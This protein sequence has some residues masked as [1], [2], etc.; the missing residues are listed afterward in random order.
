M[1]NQTKIHSCEKEKCIGYYNIHVNCRF[2][3]DKIN[4]ECLRKKDET[5]TK[6]FLF[7]LGLMVEIL[8]DA[9]DGKVYFAFHGDPDSNKIPHFT[10]AFNKT[11]PFGLTCDT[12]DKKFRNFLLIETAANT[13]MSTATSNLSVNN[14]KQATLNS[15]LTAKPIVPPT[16]DENGV[17]TLYVSSSD[18]NSTPDRIL[19]YLMEKTGMSADVLMVL[20]LRSRRKFRKTYK[21][22]KITYFTED[23]GI[24]LCK[25]DTWSSDF[26]VRAFGKSRNQIG[27]KKPDHRNVN[28]RDNKHNTNQSDKNNNKW[29]RNV[30]DKPDYRGKNNNKNWRRNHSDHR[31]GFKSLSQGHRMQRDHSR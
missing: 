15:T 20:P 6:K 8:D 4:A 9:D 19:A 3:G 29:R 7:M 23:V 11:S 30:R 2:C 16:R 22:F 17:F 31:S 10:D 12:C 21:A 13:S 27:N 25:N 24:V 18:I 28:R 1:S 5:R 14:T 26:R